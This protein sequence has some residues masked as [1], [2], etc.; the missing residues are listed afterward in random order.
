MFGHNWNP[1]EL[2]KNGDITRMLEGQYWNYK[3]NKSY[4]EGQ[5]TIGFVKIKPNE[6]YWLLFHIGKVTKDLNLLDSVGYEFEPLSE[7]DKYLGRLVIR[8]KNKSQT[9]IRKAES[10]IESCEVS[11]ILDD[12]FDNEIFPGYEK[13]NVAWQEL[14]RL[15]NRSNWI[16]ALQNQKGIYLI[17]DKSNGKKYIG[18]AYGENMILGRWKSY[19]K[20]CHGGNARLKNLDKDHIKRNFHYSILDIYKSSTDD[21]TILERESWWKN[22]LMTRE[23]GYNEN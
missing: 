20:T 21:Q 12:T 8:F 1:I 19:I 22:V 7:Y 23:F 9:M 15:I 16:T 4:K 11:Q 3:R 10:V 13:V 18:S 2:F 17:T 6:D 5:T 14:K